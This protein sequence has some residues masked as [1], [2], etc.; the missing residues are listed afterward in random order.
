MIMVNRI[1]LTLLIALAYSVSRASSPIAAD[2]AR[3]LPLASCLFPLVSSPIAAN[4]ANTA[5]P[6]LRLKLVKDAFDSDDIAIGFNAAGTLQYNDQLDSR[7]FPGIDAA[8]GLSSISSDNVRL[9]VNI[10]PLPK[11][12]P[13][14][15][16]LDVEAAN[17]GQF[18]LERTELDSI[19]QLY[20][21]WLMYKFAKDSLDLR[22]NT[23]YTFN[24]NKNDTT[25]F[26]SNRFVVVIR[27][28]QALWMHLLSFDA[29]KAGTGAEISWTTENEENYT[30]FTV[31][32]SIDDGKT[33]Y[34]LDTLT[35]TGKGAYSYDDKNPVDGADLY[36]L[37]LTD[38]NGLVS[39]STIVTL[40]FDGTKTAENKLSIYPN[41]S[42][43]VINLA[44]APQSSNGSASGSAGTQSSGI[45]QSLAAAPSAAGSSYAIKI[46]NIQGAVIKTATSSSASWQDNVSSL[47]PGT[48]II[49]VVSNSDKSLVGKSTFVKL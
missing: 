24:I 45:M 14:S 34:T 28:N 44:I 19:P 42:N 32:R 37:M 41:P 49:Q 47:S 1:V 48:Y 11:Q 22:T 9:S 33:F 40:N 35:S 6:L 43:G 3:L 5:Y 8:E 29:I 16:R 30:G 25:S 20:D 21:F 18:T 39:Y 38:M 7:Y 17:S 12:N 15:I 10:V 26:G 31:Q 36:R 46:I 2:N 4:N 13:L 23:S 27:Q